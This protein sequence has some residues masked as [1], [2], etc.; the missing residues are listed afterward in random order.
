M[1]NVTKFARLALIGAALAAPTLTWAKSSPGTVS[2]PPANMV[3]LGP[4]TYITMEL[5]QL[6]NPSAP[7]VDADL[8]RQTGYEVDAQ[9]LTPEGLRAL[10]ADYGFA[11]N[12]YSEP[13]SAYTDVTKSFYVGGYGG[14]GLNQNLGDGRSVIAG[15]FR[16]K[17]GARTPKVQAKT[18]HSDGSSIFEEAVRESL[19]AKLVDLEMPYGALKTLAVVLPNTM[20]GHKKEHPRALIVSEDPL[21]YAHY[22]LNQK[23]RELGGEYQAEDE[24]R[25]KSAFLKITEALPK[26]EGIDLTGKSKQELFVI[27]LNET[28]DRQATQLGYAWA[29]KMY[30][31]ATSPSNM[32][33]DGR[34][35]DFGTFAFLNSYVK[36]QKLTDDGPSGDPEVFIRDLWAAFWWTLNK[37]L[38]PELRAVLPTRQTVY[39]RFSLKFRQTKRHEL[40]YKAGLFNEIKAEILETNAAKELGQILFDLAKAGNEEV[41]GTWEKPEEEL[42]THEGTYNL[43]K[44]FNALASVQTFSAPELS[45]AIQTLV[46]NL[47]R[48][49]QLVEKYADVFALQTQRIQSLGVSAEAEKE[50]RR[51]A[52]KIRNTSMS[53]MF[54][55]EEYVNNRDNLQK[56]FLRTKDTRLVQN[57]I[58]DMV[59]KSRRAFR[60]AEPLT[61][62]LSERKTQSGRIVRQIYDAKAGKYRQ[63]EVKP[64]TTAMVCDDILKAAKRGGQR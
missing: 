42:A 19:I 54:W 45:A 47:K 53:A 61:V 12:I 16:I 13:E 5:K 2:N 10:F 35:V 49:T 36:L 23:A 26:P 34:M 62:V 64:V 37:N 60:D 27:G 52:A 55:T 6:A 18:H 28:I 57:Y 21:R 32:T 41:Y 8:A 15:Q 1:L 43:E 51:A 22:I 33:L 40:V 50:Y 17:G 30:H 58:D 14:I 63:V 29:H 48:R 7:Y 59:R 24:L 20:I 25:V 38:S 9:G 56:D 11:G 39:N 44:I 31:G 4:Q 3:V 46:P